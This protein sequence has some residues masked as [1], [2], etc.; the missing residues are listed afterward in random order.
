MFGAVER[1]QGPRQPERQEAA[2]G[3]AVRERPAPAAGAGAAAGPQG[4][5][6]ALAVAA[7]DCR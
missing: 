1:L 7:L 4:V 2:E 5:L 6:E 3:L